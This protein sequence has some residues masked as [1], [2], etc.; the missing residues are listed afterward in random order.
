[1]LNLVMV[2]TMKPLLYDQALDQFSFAKTLCKMF[3]CCFVCSCSAPGET[4]DVS[5]VI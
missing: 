3:V 4:I 2:D 1:M 5:V